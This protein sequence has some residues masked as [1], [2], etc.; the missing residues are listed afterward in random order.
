[1]GHTACFSVPAAGRL[2]AGG[3]MMINHSNHSVASE[4]QDLT[5]TIVDPAGRVWFVRQVSSP[6]YDRRGATALVFLTD[7]AMRRVRDF[8]ENW[9]ELADADLYAVSLR[10]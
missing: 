4:P 9:R 2:I 8:P 5:R 7:D 6:S 10:A 1:M 3:P